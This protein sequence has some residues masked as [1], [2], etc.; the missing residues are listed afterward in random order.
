MG[1][2]LIPAET[3]LALQSVLHYIRLSDFC[4]CFWSW[5]SKDLGSTEGNDR[6]PCRKLAKHLPEGTW[7]AILTDFT[8]RKMPS[9]ILK[10]Q[11]SCSKGSRAYLDKVFP[12]TAPSSGEQGWLPAG[13][14]GKEPPSTYDYNNTWS[15]VQ[16]GLLGSFLYI[17]KLGLIAEG[18][19]TGFFPLPQ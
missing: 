10:Q 12:S 15:L 19:T 2:C 17:L 5:G 13:C 11:T 3:C 6:S 7:L 1:D 4:S 18:I 16:E 9:E 8:S 14:R